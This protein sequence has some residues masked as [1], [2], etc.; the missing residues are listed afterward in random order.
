MMEISQQQ[1]VEMRV[2]QKFI[3][4]RNLSRQ[5][6]EKRDTENF[7]W[8]SISHLLNPWLIEKELSHIRIVFKNTA[9]YS[10]WIIIN[11]LNK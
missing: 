1:Y 8:K 10:N 9:G 3:Y 7:S 2:V 6:D 5:Y 11:Y 4:I